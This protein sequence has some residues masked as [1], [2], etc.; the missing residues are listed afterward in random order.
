MRRLLSALLVLMLLVITA[1]VALAG[2]S[3]NG[4]I[5]VNASVPC[6]DPEVENAKEIFHFDHGSMASRNQVYPLFEY[7]FTGDTVHY[8]ALISDNT[9]YDVEN[10]VV[11]ARL[12]LSTNETVV[13]NVPLLKESTVSYNSMTGKYEAWFEGDYIIPSDMT[14]LYYVSIA[15]ERGGNCEEVVDDLS[16]SNYAN[17]NDL[18]ANPDLEV[19]VGDEPVTF[20]LHVNQYNQATPWPLV[21]TITCAETDREGQ[22]VIGNLTT[23]ATNLRN[24][25]SAT[26]Y[27]E[28]PASD[29]RFKKGSLTTT[30]RFFLANDPAVI[31]PVN[32]VGL[33]DAFELSGAAESDVS[34]SEQ[35]FL[36]LWF[37]AYHTAHSFPVGGSLWLKYSI[38]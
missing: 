21:F 35:L 2:H 6:T 20:S 27:D 11:Y 22:C 30:W 38:Y 19:D 14:G 17:I 31:P 8:A 9:I 7:A 1:Q 13:V 15:I 10:A 37:G 29:M 5:P 23:A 4:T 33:D 36:E 16:E 26:G 18:L 28:I 12:T 3:E 24:D 32:W 34:K 25:S